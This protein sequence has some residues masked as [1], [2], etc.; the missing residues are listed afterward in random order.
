MSVLTIDTSCGD[1]PVRLP[2]AASLGPVAAVGS[3]EAPRLVPK[4][5]CSKSGHVFHS[6]L[7][8]DTVTDGAFFDMEAN[9]GFGRL[10]RRFQQGAE[11]LEDLP[12]RHIVNQQRLVYLG[13]ARTEETLK[14][15][16]L[17][18]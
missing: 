11:H 8:P 9:F 13:Q 18:H 15:E 2:F 1:S 10:W 5:R 3:G 16:M 14:P 7:L 4:R 6:V 17:K 12:Q